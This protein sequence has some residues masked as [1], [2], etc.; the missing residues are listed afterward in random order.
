MSIITVRTTDTIACIRKQEPIR[1]IPMRM[2][3][4]LPILEAIIPIGM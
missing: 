1:A 4:F 2:V 3:F